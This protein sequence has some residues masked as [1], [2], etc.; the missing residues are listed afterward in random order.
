MKFTV[1]DKVFDIL[2]NVCFALVVAHDIDNTITNP[3]IDALLDEKIHLCQTS[4]ENVSVKTLSEVLCFR[5]AF[6]KLGINPNKFTCSIEALLSRIAKGHSIPHINAAV[7]VGNCV[8]LNHKLPIGAHD[9]DTAN[10]ELMVRFSQEGDFFTPFGSQESEKIDSNE[11]VY[12]TGH[13]VRTR[14]WIWRQSE[15]GK[16]MPSSKNIFFPIDGFSDVNKKTLLLAQEELAKLLE[17]YFNCKT[18]LAF[19]DINNKSVEL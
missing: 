19:V 9:M 4:L 18:S 14:R 1:E 6:Q 16:I 7:N 10:Q 11:L 13:S 8:S 12:A 15:E 3:E 17:K 2:P 5:E